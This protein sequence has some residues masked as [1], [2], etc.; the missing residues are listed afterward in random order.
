MSFEKRKEKLDEKFLIRKKK[1][2]RG[3]RRRHSSPKAMSAA[4]EGFIGVCQLAPS[5]LPL[6]LSPPRVLLLLLLFSLSIFF[7]LLLRLLLLPR[8]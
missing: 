8:E 3:E 7:C 2:R 4:R 5:R 6:T 1:K